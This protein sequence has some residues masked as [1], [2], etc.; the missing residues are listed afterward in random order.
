MPAWSAIPKPV[1]GMLHLPPLV[2]APR[3]D[4][5]LT[6]VRERLLRDA[7]ALVT[8]G[9]HGLML[10]NFGDTPFYPGRV[11]ASVVAQMT[12]L[13]GEVRRQCDL[14]LGINV[15]RNDGRSALAIAHA[16]GGDFIRVNILCGARVTDQGVIQGIAHRLL[17]DRTRLQARHIKILADVDVK[18]SAPLGPASVPH[19]VQGPAEQAHGTG[20]GT[21]ALGTGWGTLRSIEDEVAD[22]LQRGGADAVIVSGGGTGRP[23]AVE[24]VR[25]VKA[26]AGD[27]PILVGSGVTPESIRD[28]LPHAD[29]FIV[30]TALKVDGRV[31]NSVDPA[32]VRA[33]V[34]AL[35]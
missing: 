23:A 10:E 22:T 1:I 15:L 2:G 6:V 31:T 3:C 5:D 30:G 7:E 11:P 19:P 8:G 33:F 17:R 35:A 4:A 18:H 28:Y 14:P 26:A 16:V 29:G 9:V 34:Q 20:W 13:A 12:H 21:P 27:A 24:Q 25:R 32:R